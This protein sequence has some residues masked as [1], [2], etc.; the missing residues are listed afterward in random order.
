MSDDPS[1]PTFI[2]FEVHPLCGP[3]MFSFVC[4]FDYAALHTTQDTLPENT[5]VCVERADWC[6]GS[7]S[8]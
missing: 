1:Q 7:K 6:V 2:A 4:M 5:E 8:V 3:S